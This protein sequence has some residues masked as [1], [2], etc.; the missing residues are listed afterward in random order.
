MRREP[1]VGCCC[2][3]F[4]C[5]FSLPRMTQRTL[6]HKSDANRMQTSSSSKHTDSLL[7]SRV[8]DTL[9]NGDQ[10]E[11]FLICCCPAAAADCT[12]ERRRVD[13]TRD[14]SCPFVLFLSPCPSSFLRL[15]VIYGLE[16]V[17][18]LVNGASCCESHDLTVRESWGEKFT[19]FLTRD[20]FF[21]LSCWKRIARIAFASLMQE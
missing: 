18:F 19:S 10:E 5:A 11:G 7:P 3:L 17:Y 13:W 6:Q 12:I 21:R 14:L 2:L 20:S 15:H 1:R 8:R 16:A 9:A 4:V